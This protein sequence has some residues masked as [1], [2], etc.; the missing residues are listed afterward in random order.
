MSFSSDMVHRPATLW[1]SVVNDSPLVVR[2]KV[3][4]NRFEKRTR[5]LG[6][7][8][9]WEGINGEGSTVLAS[10]RGSRNGLFGKWRESRVMYCRK[11][12]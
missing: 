1:N 10:A 7:A 6:Y 2:V 3:D 5:Q 4:G 9:M 8:S 12:G 11:S